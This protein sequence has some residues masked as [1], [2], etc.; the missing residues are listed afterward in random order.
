MV[1]IETDVF[2]K[3]LVFIKMFGVFF[4]FVFIHSIFQ[5]CYKV[6]IHNTMEKEKDLAKK[7]PAQ[8]Y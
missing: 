8:K 1:S 6:G 5:I 3:I 2:F 4:L 7:V